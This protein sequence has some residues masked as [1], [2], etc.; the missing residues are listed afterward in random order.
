MTYEEYR[1]LRAYS[2]YDGIYLAILWI[3]SFACLIGAFK[4]PFLSMP[5]MAI[6]VSSP[7]FV[8][9]RLAKFRDYGLDG[10]I[11]FG[12]ALLYCLRV[13][14]NAAIFFAIAQYL[15]MNFLDNGQMVGYMQAMISQPEMQETFKQLNFPIKDI[16]EALDMITP[17]SFTASYLIENCIAGAVLSIPVAL[18]MKK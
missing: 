11:N 5:C 14:F 9:Y 16:S 2:W 6:A 3:G 15:Y 18:A 1:Q 13:F 4:Y 12:R 8:A 7:F 17:V 10:H